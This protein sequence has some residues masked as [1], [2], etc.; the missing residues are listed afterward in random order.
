MTT[1]WFAGCT[2]VVWSGCCLAEEAGTT[3]KIQET[4]GLSRF[5]TRVNIRSE[6]AHA[7]VPTAWQ[8]DNCR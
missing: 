7:S 4:R 8:S 1:V 2:K 6:V 3:R 5:V